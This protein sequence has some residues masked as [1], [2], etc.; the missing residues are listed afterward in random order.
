[1][2][3]E[4]L[5]PRQTL[6]PWGENPVKRQQDDIADF[7]KKVIHITYFR[8]LLMKLSRLVIKARQMVGI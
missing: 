5:E 7:D 1:M 6:F 8:Y 4:D 3:Q 2:D